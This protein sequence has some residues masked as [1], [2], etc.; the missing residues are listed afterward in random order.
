[1]CGLRRARR[2][3]GVSEAL[4]FDPLRVLKVA[5]SR[6]RNESASALPTLGL[7]FGALSTTERA[8]LDQGDLDRTRLPP[9]RCFHREKRA[10]FRILSLAP[11]RISRAVERCRPG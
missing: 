1:M 3:Y 2:V 8:R 9:H 10:L 4:I 6:T 5:W 7:S 11:A